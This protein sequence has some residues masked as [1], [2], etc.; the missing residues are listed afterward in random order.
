LAV[1]SLAVPIWPLSEVENIYDLW[2]VSKLVEALTVLMLL[3]LMQDDK[4]LNWSS[5]KRAAL[6]V[7][8]R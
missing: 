6:S 3:S 1:L 8:G 2:V 4:T 5:F 7:A